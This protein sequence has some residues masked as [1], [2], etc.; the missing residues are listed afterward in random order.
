[1]VTIWD[2]H[3]FMVLRSIE[4]PTTI[5]HLRVE[6]EK[7]NL[8]FI[9]EKAAV[10]IIRIMPVEARNNNRTSDANL[11]STVIL[12]SNLR[13]TKKAELIIH[14]NEATRTNLKKAKVTFEDE[15]N[16]K[17]RH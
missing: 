12:I 11:L 16:S 13:K 15:Q 4:I 10:R 6:E 8:L 9:V 1:M 17:S 2:Y 14:H 3:N 5:M 7:Y